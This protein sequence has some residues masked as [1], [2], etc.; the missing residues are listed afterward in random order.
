[1]SSSMEEYLAQRM[2]CGLIVGGGG[3]FRGETALFNSHTEWKAESSEPVIA[4]INVT[5]LSGN[6]FPCFLPSLFFLKGETK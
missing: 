3:G 2:M 6:P 4:F 5:F 1:M